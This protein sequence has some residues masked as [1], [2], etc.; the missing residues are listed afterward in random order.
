MDIMKSNIFV[1]HAHFFE[2]I[3]EE[4]FCLLILSFWLVEKSQVFSP[5]VLLKSDVSLF[6][7][8]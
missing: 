4:F 5:S 8:P 7:H 6:L 3:D 1:I 2:Y